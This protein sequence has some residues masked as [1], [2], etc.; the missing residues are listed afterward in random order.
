MGVKSDRLYEVWNAVMAVLMCC[1]MLKD[2][3]VLKTGATG[4]MHGPE[5]SPEIEKLMALSNLR[6]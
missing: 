3:T 1:P 5:T 4:L 6:K 2:H